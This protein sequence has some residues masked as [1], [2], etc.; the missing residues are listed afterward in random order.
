MNNEGYK[1]KKLAVKIFL[2]VIMAIVSFTMLLPFLWMISSSFK[3]SFSMFDYPIKWIPDKFDFSGYKKVW[4]GEEV[5]FLRFF[6]NSIKTTAL[7]VL[8]TF[9][10]CTLGG[11]AYAKI[12]FRGRNG[13]FLAKLST[14]M[15]PSQITMLPTFMIFKWLGIL[16]THIAIW[17]PFFLGQPFGTFLMRQYFQKVPD[18]MLDSARI[19]GA[20]YLRMFKDIALPLAQA[21]VS[22]LVFLYF[23]W[24]WN[25]YE[26]PLLYIHSTKLYTLPLAIKFFT[27]EYQTN[28][29][30]IMA[31]SVSMT[32]PVLILFIGL[33]RFFIEDITSSGLK[34]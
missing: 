15:I 29:T 34:G 21:G 19:D 10:S 31:A 13:L 11:F 26:G 4:G 28:Y 18:E 9:I 1:R 25:F 30:A 24:S 22:V 3:D 7:S 8:G 12:R 32:V 20:G 23:V 33:Q 17:L 5:D 14:M 16:D 2:T 27:D 6:M